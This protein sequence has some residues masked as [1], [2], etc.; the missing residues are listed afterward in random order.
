MGRPTLGE[1]AL[2]VVGVVLFTVAVFVLTGSA[3]EHV[4]VATRGGHVRVATGAPNHWNDYLLFVLRVLGPILVLSALYHWQTRGER[5][6]EDRPE[7]ARRHFGDSIVDVRTRQDP[8]VGMLPV[9]T[10][11][12]RR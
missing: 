10:S 9:D 11:R 6:I 3:G 1:V 8:A 7:E 2:I 4:T 12:D 5:P